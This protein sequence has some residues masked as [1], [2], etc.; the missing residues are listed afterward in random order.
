MTTSSLFLAPAI[1]A[2]IPPHSPR[3]PIGL[4]IL[5]I[6]FA[7][8]FFGLRMLLRRRS[9]NAAPKPEEVTKE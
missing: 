7:A 8:A 9:K 3:S 1:V 6:V 5:L 2:D 4:V